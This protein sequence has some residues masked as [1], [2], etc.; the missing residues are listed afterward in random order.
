MSTSLNEKVKT[1]KYK[2]IWFKDMSLRRQLVNISAHI[3]SDSIELI[4]QHGSYHYAEKS[5]E[6]M[7][8]WIHLHSVTI[9]LYCVARREYQMPITLED[10]QGLGES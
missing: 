5:P 8:K 7:F 9:R 1:W 4:C 2:G 10:F 6:D 3:I